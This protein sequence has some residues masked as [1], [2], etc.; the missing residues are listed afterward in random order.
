MKL[1]S[2]LRTT[3]TT[4]NTTENKCINISKAQNSTRLQPTGIRLF[5]VTNKERSALPSA[6]RCQGQLQTPESQEFSLSLGEE[7]AKTVVECVNFLTCFCVCVVLCKTDLSFN[8][9]IACRQTGYA[10]ESSQWDGT[11]STATM[12]RPRNWVSIPGRSKRFVSSSKRPDR[13]WVPPTF[14]YKGY[15]LLFNRR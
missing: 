7:C 10:I 12:L 4:Q 8:R 9:P 6:N 14:L 11:A 15:R 5:L 3:L 1:K 2:N 13:Q